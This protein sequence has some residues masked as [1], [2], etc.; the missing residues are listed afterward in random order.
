MAA[1][2]TFAFPEDRKYLK[3]YLEGSAHI[4][5]H[6]SH[7]LLLISPQTGI[8][9]IMQFPVHCTCIS[10]SHIYVYFKLDELRQNGDW[11]LLP[12]G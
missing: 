7:T 6:S 9:K 5:D 11:S 10:I 12:L 1:L 4:F 2:Q 8:L 3:I